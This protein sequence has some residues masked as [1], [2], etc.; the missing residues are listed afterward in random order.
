MS[1]VLFIYK[2]KNLAKQFTKH[3]KL[4]GYDVTEFYE[5]PI[6]YSPKGLQKLENILYRVLFKKPNHIHN[7]YERNFVSHSNRIIKKLKSRSL[8]FDFCFIIRGD[9]IPP[10]VLKYARSVSGKMIDYQ[11]DGLS[12]SSKILNYKDLF[13][14][15]YVFDEQDV[16][17][18]P[19]YNLKS[20][21]NCYFETQ[22]DLDTPDS[23][24]YY[25]GALVENRLQ[26]IENLYSYLG[27]DYRYHINLGSGRDFITTAPI[28]FLK[29]QISYEQ[30]LE[31]SR[32]SKVLLDFKREEH[33]GLS[34]RFFEAIGFKKKIITNNVAVKN[35]D[36]YD[37]QNIFIT[38]YTHFDG[39]AD[40]LQ[41]PYKALDKAITDKYQF[42]TW[43]SKLLAGN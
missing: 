24:I 28:R 35:Y 18:Y 4:N 25:T 19:G 21:T 3:F 43:I 32:K 1:S 20:T 13:D 8:H 11:L 39:L 2:N 10:S 23:D 22:N 34:L 38:D 42:K 36:F 33:D 17:D 14:Q 41:T 37:P 31:Y 16:M 15:I 40:V 27:D 6:P 9:L 29:E 5:A 12:V 7:I 26:A 30:N